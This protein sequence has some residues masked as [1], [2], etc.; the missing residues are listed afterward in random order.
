MSVEYTPI[1]ARAFPIYDDI[2]EML[3]ETGECDDYIFTFDA[4]RP[5]DYYFGKRFPISPGTAYPISLFNSYDIAAIDA[6]IA[7]KAASVY[8]PSSMVSPEWL[9]GVRII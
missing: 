2:A 8:L 6:E 3:A 1:V 4:Y 5:S 7:E 9:M